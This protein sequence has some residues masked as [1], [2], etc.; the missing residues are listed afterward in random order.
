MKVDVYRTDGQVSGK[1]I[2][3]SDTVFAAPQKDH[4]VYLVVKAQ[5]ANMRQGTHAAKNRAA[6]R[7]GG[8]KPWRQ[9]GRGVARAGTTRSPLWVGGGRVFGPQP[10]DYSQKVNKKAKKVARRS[11]LS[12]R[13]QENRLRVLEDFTVESGK[14]RD[15]VAILNNFAIERERVLLLVDAADSMLLRASKNVPNLQVMQADLV[16][17]YDLLRCKQVFLQK[18]AVAKLEEVLA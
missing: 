9:K 12:A 18:S 15:V 3:L 5:L 10:R 11:V 4:V 14:T 17:V 1:K 2:N 8:K 13:L 6:V 16:S 7:G